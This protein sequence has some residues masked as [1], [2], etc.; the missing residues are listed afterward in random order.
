MLPSGGLGGRG[1]EVEGATWSTTHVCKL[2]APGRMG[3]GWDL[4]PPSRRGAGL[5]G[6][7]EQAEESAFL[8]DFSGNHRPLKAGVMWNLPTPVSKEPKV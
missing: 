4:V 6:R 7:G 1:Q 2:R 3:L 5:S 8:W